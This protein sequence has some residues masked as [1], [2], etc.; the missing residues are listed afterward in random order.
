MN[1][2]V[3]APSSGEMNTCRAPGRVLDQAQNLPVG[4]AE[5]ESWEQT[6]PGGID[7]E[8]GPLLGEV[9]AGPREY[10]RARM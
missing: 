8:P 4:W 7:G 5:P 1:P 10:S 3:G 2:K 9:E 6:P